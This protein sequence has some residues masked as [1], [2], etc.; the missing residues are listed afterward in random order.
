MSGWRP[1]YCGE[2]VGQRPKTKFVPLTLASGLGS[3]NR[4]NLVPEEGFFDVGVDR[5]AGAG[6]VGCDQAQACLRN[7]ALE[8]DQKQSLHV[9]YPVLPCRA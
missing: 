3:W 5:S 1:P 8:Q 6:W 2:W 9:P 7:F 4:F